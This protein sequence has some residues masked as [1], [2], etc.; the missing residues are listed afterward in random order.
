MHPL[1]LLSGILSQ[2]RLTGL[3]PR[4]H[5]VIWE[6]KSVRGYGML[7]EFSEKMTE[8]NLHYVVMEEAPHMYEKV[9]QHVYHDLPYLFAR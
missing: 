4:N 7:F 8:G 3:P 6:I 2:R 1:L 9:Y 5:E